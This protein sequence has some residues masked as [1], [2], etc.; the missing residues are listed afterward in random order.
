[1]GDIFVNAPYLNFNIAVPFEVVP[2]GK[3][4][5]GNASTL[6]S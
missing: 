4:S 1:M 3:I 2:Y 6:P 5:K